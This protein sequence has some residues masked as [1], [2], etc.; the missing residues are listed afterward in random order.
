MADNSLTGSDKHTDER[1]HGA[2]AL[3]TKREISR[4]QIVATECNDV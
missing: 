1:I 3:P 4:E 2:N